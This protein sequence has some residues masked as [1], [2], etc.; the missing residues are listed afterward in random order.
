MNPLMFD[1][2][3]EIYLRSY[4]CDLMCLLGP[5]RM[6]AVYCNLL[7]VVTVVCCLLFVHALKVET[8]I[9]NSEF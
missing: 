8:K 9:Q 4:L 3:D 5:S 7:F 6:H 1:V 2:S